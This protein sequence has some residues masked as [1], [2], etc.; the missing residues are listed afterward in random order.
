[1]PVVTTVKQTQPQNPIGSITLS[2]ME[3]SANDIPNEVTRQALYE[4]DHDINLHRF[5]NADEMFAAL[6]I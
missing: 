5:N 6:G 2:R 1:M 3:K 4:V